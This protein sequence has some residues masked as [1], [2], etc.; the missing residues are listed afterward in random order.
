MSQPPDRLAGDRFRGDVRGSG[1]AEYQ[2]VKSKSINSSSSDKSQREISEA[3]G[4]E[5]CG[6]TT[7]Q[8]SRL[9]GGFQVLTPERE[10]P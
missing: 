1:T 9:F 7:Q 3:A 2:R 5:S 4:D 8:V 6:L 10:Q